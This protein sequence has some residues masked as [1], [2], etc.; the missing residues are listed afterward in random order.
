MKY[1]ESLEKF[2]EQLEYSLKNYKPHGI[3]LSNYNQVILAGLG[4]SGISAKIIKSYF[5]DKIELP[6]EVVS[7]Y[8]L[9]KFADEKTLLILCSYSGNTEE[10]LSV[11]ADGKEK[12]CGIM[13]ISA[14][15]KLL[16]EAQQYNYIHYTLPNGFQPRMTIGYGL[17]TLFLIFS[18]LTK[19]DAKKD[20]QNAIDT[21]NNKE[22]WKPE[23]DKFYAFFKETA[24]Q[25]FSISSDKYLDATSLRFCQQ[26]NENSKAEA[27][28]N[29]L[30]EVNHNVIE[31]YYGKLESNFIFIHTNKNERI[32]LR[33]QFLKTLLANNNNKVYSFV[34]EDYNF[35]EI[36]KLIHIHDWFSV[37]IAEDQNIDVLNIENIINLKNFLSS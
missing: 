13:I 12:K 35:T 10:T 18:E 15:G 16:A 32:T 26:L 7:D 37:K 14:G 28:L 20:I 17:T 25:K 21:L 34:L 3:E 30:P 5:F 19:L 36:I 24:Q 1:R 6:I 22:N 29:V 23:L 2:P 4:G 8:N 27:F 9:P 31:S 11:L 33:F